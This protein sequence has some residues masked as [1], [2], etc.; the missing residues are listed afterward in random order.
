MRAEDVGAVTVAAA[1]PEAGGVAGVLQVG[2]DRAHDGVVEGDQRLGDAE[3]GAVVL[4]GVRLA[5]DEPAILQDGERVGEIAGLA[6][7]IGGNAATAGVSRRD[8]AEHRVVEARVVQLG[9]LAQQ[10]PSFPE[11]RAA[12]G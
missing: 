5:G 4:E 11:Q 2:P 7:E 1:F 3:T 12:G 6:A 9:L 8:R 10:H